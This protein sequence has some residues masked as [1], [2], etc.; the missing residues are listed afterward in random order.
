MRHFDKFLVV[1]T[2]LERYNVSY[3]FDE[4]DL[5]SNLECDAWWFSIDENPEK[6]VWRED[7]AVITLWGNCKL[8][9]MIFGKKKGAEHIESWDR[10]HEDL[11]APRIIWLLKKLGY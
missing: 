6:G 8:E 7:A 5:T 4:V 10:R 3:E 9:I 1:R 2:L 11:W